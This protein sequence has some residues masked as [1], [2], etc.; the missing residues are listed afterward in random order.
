MNGVISIRLLSPNSLCALCAL[1]RDQ[2]TR[3]SEA[4]L[5]IGKELSAPI[6]FGN[7][8]PERCRLVAGK[9]AQLIAKAG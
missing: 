5:F 1:A 2:P 9:G 8:P 7:D 3:K 4:P 6:H